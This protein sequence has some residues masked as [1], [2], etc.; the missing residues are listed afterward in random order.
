MEYKKTLNLPKTK[1]PMR[2]GLAKKEPEFLNQWEK[3][4]LYNYLLNNRKTADDFILHDGPP[5]ANGKIH[6]GTALNKILKDII[7]KYKTMQGFKAPYVPGWDTHGLPIEHHV[8]KELGSKINDMSKLEIRGK[9]AEYA[10]K[11]VDIQRE[12]F[13]RLGV[14]G[15]WDNPYLTLNPQYESKVLETLKALVETDNVYRSK[16]VVHWCPNCETALA[17][18]EIEYADETSDSIYVKFAMKDE[19]NTYIIIW[20]TTPWTLPANLAIAV[21]PDFEYVQFDVDGEKWIMAKELTSELL[22]KIGKSEDVLFEK[23]WKGKE[24]EGKKALHPFLD[25]ESLVVLADYVTLETGTGCVHTAPGHGADDYLTGI[26]YGLDVY[27]PVNS[28]GRYTEEFPQMKG[29][30]VFKANAKINAMLEDMGK[31]VLAEKYKHSYPHCWRCKKPIIFRATEQW[32][33]SIDKN[34]LRR[35]VLDEIKKT[36]WVPSWGENRITAMISDRPDWCISRQRAWGIPIPAYYCEDCGKT[37]MNA[38]TMDHVI[39]IVE[40]EGTNAWFSKDVKELL[41]AGYQCPHCGGTHFTK[42][43]DILDVWIDS[44]SSFESVIRQRDV[45]RYPADCYIEGSDQH[46][47]WFNSS[48]FL[49]VAKYGIAPFKSVV[50]HGFIRDGK[51]H[52]MSKSLG[53]VILPQEVIE[54]Y[55]AD[56]L[57]LWVGSSDYRN[58]IN[59]SLGI[60]KQYTDSYKKIRNTLRFLL[61]NLSDYDPATD[62]VQREDLL[63]FDRWALSRLNNLIKTVQTNYDDFEFYKGVQAINRYIV[64]DLSNVYLDVLKDRLYVEGTKSL[65]RRSGQT[66][67]YEIMT[68]LTLMLAPVLVFTAEEVYNYFP[69]S[70]RKFETVHAL[71]WP[72]YNPDA[73]DLELEKKWRKLLEIKE[74]VN[75]TLEKSRTAGT[76]GHSLDAHCTLKTSSEEIYQLLESQK[77]ML[78]RFFIVS[79]VRLEKCDKT[80]AEDGLDI[81]VEHAKGEKCQRCWNYDEG[82]GSNEKYPNTC[83]RCADIL[84]EFYPDL[85][86]LE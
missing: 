81:L 65:A 39:G 30:F 7:I 12:D 10:M 84:E 57:R 69:E 1:F 32:F 27:S 70:A 78:E 35:K 19:P 21:H 55:G 40:K 46:R 61:G 37:I 48:I 29:E 49:S 45:L 77:A 17:E 23:T 38:Q 62:A 3:L 58:D 75:N 44:G 43:E 54:Q 11:Y 56:I 28:Q 5:Y 25:R 15:E 74:K 26:K 80:E 2:A 67:M 33:I 86:A 59:V 41:P 9:C 47:G 82:T 51:G 85:E 53:N 83:P 8:S 60:L 34:N 22:K 52:K 42:E 71:D 6:I 63:E 68:A 66:V 76:V 14:A 72:E 36:K 13:K 31:M 50:T 73:V 18:A 16:K 20:T 79:Q 64:S 24:L 4:D